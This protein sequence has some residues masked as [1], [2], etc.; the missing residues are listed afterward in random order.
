MFDTAMKHLGPDLTSIEVNGEDL[1]DANML[2]CTQSVLDQ[3]PQLTRLRLENLQY[4]QTTKNKRKEK[5][6]Y[7]QH[8]SQL[9]ELCVSHCLLDDIEWM[10]EFLKQ[11]P[12]LET[13]AFHHKDY[14][15][16]KRIKGK[17]SRSIFAGLKLQ[18][19]SMY[20]VEHNQSLLLDAVLQCRETLRH[21]FFKFDDCIDYSRYYVSICKNLPELESI[22]VMPGKA[23]DTALE[24]LS[25]MRNLR[26]I[27]MCDDMSTE[28]LRKLA[29]GP[30]NVQHLVLMDVLMSY[31]ICNTIG[32]FSEKL[33]TLELYR[34]KCFNDIMLQEMG[35][36]LQQ[37]KTL[38]IDSCQGNVISLSTAVV[39]ASIALETVDLRGSLLDSTILTETLAALRSSVSA[40]N[41]DNAA[42][43]V[44]RRV[45]FY[46][47]DNIKVRSNNVNARNNG[48]LYRRFFSSDP[49]Q[50]IAGGQ[51]GHNELEQEADLR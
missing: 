31:N 18:T 13:L 38:K 9:K 17:K 14:S 20:T 30:N 11:M 28:W 8:C 23:D 39:R 7:G 3:S 37:L 26:K 44:K 25:N 24:H 27:I 34:V 50:K 4:I 2:F 22:L 40:S 19:L 42:G 36:K 46:W 10:S 33:H 5:I 6:T 12:D 41:A 43:G 21:L 29:A 49:I 32:E 47:P 35:G 51:H 48:N 45:F 1:D 16:N 15:I